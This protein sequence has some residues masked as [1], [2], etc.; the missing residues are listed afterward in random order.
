MSGPGQ[1][2]E[3]DDLDS[4][5]L[6]KFDPAQHL[7]S[8]EAISA[9]MTDILASGDIVL[10]QSAVNDVLRARLSAAVRRGTR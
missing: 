6:E 9:Y 3:L 1:N 2:F 5:E 10:F 4:L 8:C 7:T